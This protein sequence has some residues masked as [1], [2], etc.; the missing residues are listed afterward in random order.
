MISPYL[1]YPFG[2]IPNIEASLSLQ[3]DDDWQ[4]WVVITWQQEDG[5]GLDWSEM[6]QGLKEGHLKARAIVEKQNGIYE[7]KATKAKGSTITIKYPNLDLYE[8]GKNFNP[9]H[10]LKVLVVDDEQAALD[11]IQDSLERQGFITFGATDCIAALEIFQK[12]KPQ[13]SIIDAHMPGSPIDGIQAIQRMKE[14]DAQACC[15]M[16]T[17]IE[18]DK[19]SIQRAK[20]LGVIAYFVKPFKMELFNAF[21]MEAKGYAG[22]CQEVEK[23]SRISYSNS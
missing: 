2:S 1:P 19:F 12:E 10:C 14:T 8:I 4:R 11:L 16:L 5:L 21:V 17:H 15:I 6:P 13:I 7:Y 3:Y 9:G 18:N 22:L 23:W 20:D